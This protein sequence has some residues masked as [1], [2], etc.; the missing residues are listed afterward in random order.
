M[1][2]GKE[3]PAVHLSLDEL[4]GLE[5]LLREN[6]SN[7]EIEIV[8]SLRGGVEKRFNSVDQID[9]TVFANISGSD[10]YTLSV[11]GDEGRCTIGGES[12]KSESHM[13]YSTGEPDWRNTIEYRVKQYL[14]SVQSKESWLREPLAGKRATVVAVLGA[15]FVGWAIADIAP[16]SIVHYYPTIGDVL[17]FAL[18][19]FVLLLVR[20]RNWVHPY[21]LIEYNQ[22]H[23][24]KERMANLAMYVVFIAISILMLRWWMGPGPLLR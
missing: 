8:L 14:Y 12:T 5:E 13:I 11:A 23:P 20:F 16:Q 9:T 17:T 19:V 22:P 18:G 6:T 2:N 3:L 7:C 1:S 4:R 10:A 21:V 15:L 24:T